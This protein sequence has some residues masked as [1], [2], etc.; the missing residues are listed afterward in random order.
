MTKTTE[1]FSRQRLHSLMMRFSLCLLVF[2][3]GSLHPGHN[4]T[5]YT[6][7]ATQHM[8]I[9]KEV[10][11]KYPI[12]EK[13][14]QIYILEQFEERW[15]N[16]ITEYKRVEPHKKGEVLLKMRDSYIQIHGLLRDAC[17]KLKK[18]SRDIFI[19]YTDKVQNRKLSK[20]E[21]DFYENSF[22]VAKRETRRAKK[23]FLRRHFSYSARLYDRSVIIL[24]NTYK[25]L[26]WALPPTYQK[27]QTVSSDNISDDPLD[28]TF[29]LH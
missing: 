18:Y 24:A 2:T 6:Q 20:S 10:Y 21:S 29:S 25:K 14:H 12:A 15:Q 11:N 28:Q 19:D 23:A 1:A 26:N 9:L 13:D 8:E 27:I 17:I 7:K 5:D 16:L 4:Y 22:E 3:V